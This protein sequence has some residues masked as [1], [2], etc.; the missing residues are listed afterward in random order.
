MKEEIKLGCIDCSNKTE[1]ILT[2]HH[3]DGIRQN[4]KK[5]NLEVVCSNCHIKRHLY[6]NENGNGII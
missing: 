5:E 1:Y 2:V 4:N 3:K 6:K